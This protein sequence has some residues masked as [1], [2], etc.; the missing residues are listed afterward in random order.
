MSHMVMRLSR[1]NFSQKEIDAVTRILEIGYTPMGPEVHQFEKDIAEYIGNDVEVA[2]VNTGT[3][4]LHLACQAIGLGPG[5]E[6]LVP[7]LTYVASFQAIRATGAKPIACDV[8]PTTAILDLEDAKK[9]ITE[10][11]KAIMLVHYA[12]YPGNL[13]EL[14]S[15]AKAKNLRVVEDAAHS[16]GCEYAGKKIGSFGDVICFSFDGIKNITSGEGGAVVSHDQEVMQLVR[17]ARLL[18]IQNDSEKRIKGERSWTFNVTHQGWRYHMSEIMAA[19]GRVQLERFKAGELSDL[20]SDLVKLYRKELAEVSGLR[21]FD[22]PENEGDR[23]IPHIFPIRILNG[24][25]DE[26]RDFLNSKDIQCGFHYFPS[27]HLDLFKTD[28]ALPGVELVESEIVTLPLHTLL[29]KE[30]VL[31]VCSQIKEF[32]G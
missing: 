24:K 25:R 12:S 17:D 29:S 3:A 19:I 28:Y 4:A 18:G 14:Y 7:S 5:D 2:C 30:D 22:H 9:R 16:F 8:D 20:R 6:V 1:S 23:I 11:T 21:L 27:H 26:F 13:D 10:N 15:F 31:L 32:L